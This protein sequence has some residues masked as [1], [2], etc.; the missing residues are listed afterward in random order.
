MGT[1]KASLAP[2][3]QY[4]IYLKTKAL[5]AHHRASTRKSFSILWNQR[6]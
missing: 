5:C 2:L 3:G 4:L 1:T 6:V